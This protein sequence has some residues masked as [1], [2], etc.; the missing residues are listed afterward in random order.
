[1]SPVEALFE[2]LS[3]LKK[4]LNIT[5]SKESIEGKTPALLQGYGGRIRFFIPTRY[6][7]HKR[8]F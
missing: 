5:Y 8:R 4:D 1:M 6:I 3:R 7:W 2:T